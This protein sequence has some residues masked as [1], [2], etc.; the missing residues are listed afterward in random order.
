MIGDVFC[1]FLIEFIRALLIDELSEYVRGR[2]G[3]AK[4]ARCRRSHSKKAVRLIRS[5]STGQGR[6]VR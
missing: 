5:L 2:V 6:K 3:P 1:Q 4:Q